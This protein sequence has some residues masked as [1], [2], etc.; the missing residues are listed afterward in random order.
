MPKK[1][2]EQEQNKRESSMGQ[3]RANF[4]LKREAIVS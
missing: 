3:K 4:G 2:K 1:K